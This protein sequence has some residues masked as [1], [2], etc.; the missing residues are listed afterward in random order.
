MNTIHRSALGQ[1]SDQ[2][3]LAQLHLAAQAE[4]RATAHLVAL[5]I[6]LDSRRLYLGEGFSLAVRVLHRRASPLGARR[7]Q[8]H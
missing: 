8:P 2:D 3:L 6:E 7:V 5:L 1:L 4:H